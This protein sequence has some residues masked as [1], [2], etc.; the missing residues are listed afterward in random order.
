MKH[1]DAYWTT[2]N[3]VHSFSEGQYNKGYNGE[4]SILWNSIFRTIDSAARGVDIGCGNGGLALLAVQ[5]ENRFT[6]FG[7]DAANIQ[8]LAAIDTS[9]EHFKMLPEISF[10]AG[11]KAENLGF[12]A[13]Y[14]DFA[15]SQ[16]GIEY[17]E[18]NLSIPEVSRVLKPGGRFIAMLHHKNSF[19]TISSSI[20]L[21]VL[22][23][24][25][26]KNSIVDQL[27]KFVTF[28]NSPQFTYNMQLAENVATFQT[29]NKTLLNS[30]KAVQQA[31]LNEANIHWYNDISKM[32]V[33]FVMSW[34]SYS[35]EDFEQVISSIQQ[36]KSRL[37]DQISCAKSQANIKE[38]VDCARH[39]F[40]SIEYRPIRLKEGLFAWCVEFIK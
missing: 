14:F 2:R 30:F 10:F 28:Y 40:S 33:P 27:H 24:F 26:A 34:Q 35:V 29:Y 20:G 22:A 25:L 37:G 4:L 32:L 21:E 1:W 8:P 9:L 17:S 12:D 16:F 11:M 3:A 19:V 15:I 6:M 7:C 39:T 36:F 18:L 13:N 23:N 38:I 31:N 5:S